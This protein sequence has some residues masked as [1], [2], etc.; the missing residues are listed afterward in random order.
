MAGRGKRYEGAL[1]SFDRDRLYSPGE[2]LALVKRLATARF[3]ETIELS[4]RLGIDPRK[5]DQAVRGTLSLPRGTGKQ[6]RVV[7]FAKGDKAKEAREAG[8]DEVGDQDLIARVE[9]GW[10]DFDVAIATSEMMPAVGKL[11]KIL[12]PRGLMPNPKSGTVTN[13]VGKAVREVK[14]GKVEYRN[15]KFGNVHLVI[16]KASFPLEA[17]AENYSAVIEEILRVKPSAAKGKYLKSV[18]LASSMGPAIRIDPNSAKDVALPQ[19]A[20]EPATAKVG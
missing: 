1:Q 5:A 2:A 4:M 6:V 18:A 20:P 15:D 11:G 9:K 13:D 16:G 17:L 3:D 10:T 14:A 7:V 12:G 8:A 19:E